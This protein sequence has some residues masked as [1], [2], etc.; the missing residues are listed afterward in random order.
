MLSNRRPRIPAP[1]PRWAPVSVT[2]GAGLAAAVVIPVTQ[3]SPSL[4][5]ISVAGVAVH[6]AIVMVWSFWAGSAIARAPRKATTLVPLFL[7][8]ALL[9]ALTL[10]FLL[11]EL[12]PFPAALNSWGRGLVFLVGATAYLFGV[13]QSRRGHARGDFGT[14]GAREAVVALRGLTADAS[15]VTDLDGIVATLAW[16]VKRLVDTDRVWVLLPD[17]EKG[18]YESHG[19]L[20]TPLSLQVGSPIVQ[21]LQQQP[22][23]LRV[24]DLALL[25]AD[26]SGPRSE[27]QALAA[28]G[29]ALL[30]PI[31]C[32]RDRLTAI[33]AMGPKTSGGPYTDDDTRLLMT[34]ALEPVVATLEGARLYSL[35]HRRAAQL[36]ELDRQKTD[37]L[38]TVSHQLK[39][40]VTSIKV[41]LGL[42]VEEVTAT[43]GS[44][45]ERLLTSASHGVEAL[46]KLVEDLLD[47]VRVRSAR[48]ELVLEPVDLDE[49]VRGAVHVISPLAG[50]KEQEL[51][52][53]IPRGMPPVE[54]D[55]KRLVQVLLNLLS[56]A[57]QY[58]AAGQPI[59][60]TVE[61]RDQYA[62]VSV[63]D[64]CGGIPPE[65]QAW[66]FDAYYRS[67]QSS[68]A[69]SS[70]GSG[71]G[72][73]IAKG[74]VEL[75]GGRIWVDSVPGD[76]C[77]FSFS[78][79]LERAGD[80]GP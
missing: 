16:A 71:L 37:F 6:A 2:A 46:E 41:A 44:P 17:P 61:R 11:E 9:Y 3:L 22:D 45:V 72:L 42:L 38:A 73:A 52:V 43:S 70:S 15:G 36:Q 76:G 47:F 79:P 80:A 53:Q 58:S 35:E 14:A 26:G 31:T 27:V 56:N 62:V 21:R 63:Q 49:V 67:Q 60:V 64:R 34:V 66:I 68:R 1:I 4:P 7:G 10:L 19:D 33:L 20:P 74:L 40:P 32:I 65:D 18:A 30:V 75:H 51:L 54:A 78:L 48:M 69:S 23:C 5:A 25:P 57:S 12:V 39:T 29:V 77:T 28:A 13:H 24:E 50:A 55:R 8:A 59:T